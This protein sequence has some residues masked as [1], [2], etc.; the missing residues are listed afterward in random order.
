MHPDLITI[1]DRLVN[2][3]ASYSLS[4]PIL[5]IVSNGFTE[6]SRRLCCELER[7]YGVGIDR[8]SF[9]TGIRHPYF[10][11]FNDAPC[12]DPAFGEC[13]YSLG[14]W[15]PQYCGIGLNG[16]GFYACAVMG[17]IDR[18][19]NEDHSIRHLSD[20]NIDALR[21]QCSLLCRY[22]G[23]FKHYSANNGEFIPRCEKPPYKGLVS[24]TWLRLYAFR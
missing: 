19:L 12:D 14:C 9:K 5:E 18:M 1:V 7:Q 6:K 21:R 13:D 16:K 10:T 15:V 23:N 8:K 22:C 2:G 11:D 17:G 4:K 3:F 24:S 20:V